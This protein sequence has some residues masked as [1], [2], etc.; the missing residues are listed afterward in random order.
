MRCV[1]HNCLRLVIF[2]RPLFF[3]KQTFHSESGFGPEVL[4]QFSVRFATV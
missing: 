1:K 2:D 4:W 3:P